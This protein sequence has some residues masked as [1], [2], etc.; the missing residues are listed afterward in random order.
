MLHERTFAFGRE[1]PD[2]VLAAPAVPT[3]ETISDWLHNKPAASAKAIAAYHEPQPWEDDR[4]AVLGDRGRDGGNRWL[5]NVRRRQS[6][7]QR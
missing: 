2:I 4:Y 6:G 5:V 3:S 1:F 7:Y